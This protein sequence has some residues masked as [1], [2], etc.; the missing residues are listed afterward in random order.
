ME[1]FIYVY[2]YIGNKRRKFILLLYSF[3]TTQIMSS[4]IK[5]KRKKPILLL[6]AF[7]YTQKRVLNTTIYWKCKN[8]VY[9]GRAV[10]YK[11]NPPNMTKPHNHDGDEMKCKMEE[12]RTKLKRR[13]EDSPQPVKKIIKKLYLYIQAHQK[14]L[15]LYECLMK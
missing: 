9:P 4:I 5:N 2:I 1:K 14:L 12:F 11:S 8:R 6:D 15:H 10:Q 3:T 7:H 13:I